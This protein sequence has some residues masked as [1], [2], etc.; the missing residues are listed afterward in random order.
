MPVVRVPFGDPDLLVL[1]SNS[2]G[3]GP[4]TQ[5]RQTKPGYLDHYNWAHA[6]GGQRRNE[7]LVSLLSTCGSAIR[8]KLCIYIMR[9]GTYVCAF[10]PFIWGSVADVDGYPIRPSWQLQPFAHMYQKQC[11][12]RE[13][14]RTLGMLLMAVPGK[15]DENNRRAGAGT[16]DLM[17][18]D[19]AARFSEC[20]SNMQVCLPVKTY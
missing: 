1:V 2:N 4:D 14:S 7:E 6:H 17:N 18:D 5:D 13:Y 8:E 10:E 9:K 3:G 16:L 20:S 15:D 11:C 19:V 12:I